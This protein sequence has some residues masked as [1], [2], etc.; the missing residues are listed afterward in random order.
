MNSKV[1]LR[2]LLL[3]AIFSQYM[4]HEQKQATLDDGLLE[5]KPYLTARA[6]EFY[7]VV[8]EGKKDGYFVFF[9]AAW[10]GHCTSFKAKFVELAKK[11][12]NGE[13]AVNPTCILYEIGDNDPIT[14]FFKVNAFPTLLYIKDGRYCSYSGMRD[15]LSL[16]DFFSNPMTGDHC[17]DFLSSYPGM[18][19]HYYNK[20][21]EVYDQIV[22]EGS[23]YLKEYPIAT[24]CL[25]GV[26]AVA[27]IINISGLLFCIYSLLCMKKK[28]QRVSKPTK[29]E[30]AGSV[31]Q[32]TA[33]HDQSAKASKK[34]EPEVEQ[35]RTQRKYSNTHR[36]SED[37]QN[38]K[39]RGE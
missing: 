21:T 9:G 36:A 7:D 27:M 17:S 38:L 22:Y 5:D 28:S 13:L 3:I 33:T 4:C 14:T 11:S 19:D 1:T 12:Q 8:S 25:L 26:M 6:K 29:S 35:I 37:E 18:I 10:C 23:Y 20:A 24:K 16:V 30:N 39:K 34:D 32:S 15:E 31:R 2:I